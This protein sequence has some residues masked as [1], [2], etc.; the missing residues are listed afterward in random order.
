MMG[1]YPMRKNP[2]RLGGGRI[3]LNFATVNWTNQCAA[4]IPCL[5]EARAIAEVVRS[6]RC[7]VP[8]V[9]VID[10]GS[11]DNTGALA[12]MAGAEVLRH[13]IPRGKGMALQTG[14]EQARKRGF[15]WAMTMDGDGQ[16][17]AN[18]VAQ[19]FE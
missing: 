3:S 2:K 6:V 7:I 14:W 4:V 9:F 13:E 8:T 18:D 17:S 10:D 1:K 16:H 12:K 5:N 19:F 15:E 11:R